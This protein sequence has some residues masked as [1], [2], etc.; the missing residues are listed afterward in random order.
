M[1]ENKETSE[2]SFN[3]EKIKE[4]KHNLQRKYSSRLNIK[5]VFEAWD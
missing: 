5:R 1:L 4:I 3:L 2:G